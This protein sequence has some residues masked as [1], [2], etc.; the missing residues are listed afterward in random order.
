MLGYRVKFLEMLIKATTTN[1]IKIDNKYL[2]KSGK[3]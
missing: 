2:K 1:E 3:T